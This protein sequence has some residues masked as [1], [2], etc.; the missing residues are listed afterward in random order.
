MDII[1]TK[2][3]YDQKTIEDIENKLSQKY[4]FIYDAFEAVAIKGPEIL[5]S[6]EFKPEIIEA[7]EHESK[8]NSNPFHRSKSSS[9]NND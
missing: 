5:S 7:I 6:F 9:R 1:K 3:E 4:D 2:L 8:K